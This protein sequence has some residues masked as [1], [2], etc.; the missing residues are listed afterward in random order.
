MS[1]S[2]GVLR[3]FLLTSALIA[4]A[5]VRA[6]TTSPDNASPINGAA[7]VGQ[8]EAATTPG[9]PVP[10][11]D[12]NAAAAAQAQAQPDVS[13]PGGAGDIVVTGQRNIVRSSTEVS[14]VL[15]SADIARTGEGDIAGALARVTGLSVVGNGYVYVRGLGDRYSLALL[16]GL[17]LPSPEPLKRVVPL[18]L[19]ATTVI[20]SSLVQKSYSANFPGEFGGGVINLTTISA[21]KESFLTISGGGG[22]DTETTAHLGYTYYGSSL[23]W[24]G[25]TNANRAPT[26]ALKD[27]FASGKR[28]GDPDVDKQAIATGIFTGRNSVVQRNTDI[29]ANSSASV[30]AGTSFDLGDSTLGIIANAGYSNSWRTRDTTQQTPSSADLSQKELDYQRVI[31]DDHIVVNGL[32]GVSLESGANKV[33]LT[34]LFIR[35]TLKQTRLGRGFET[36]TGFTRLDEDTAWYE[37]Q[38]IDTQLAGQFKLGNLGV[39]VRGG[40]ANTK[41]NAPYELSAG[42]VR[43]NRAND[44]FGNY[45][46][47]RLNN[48]QTGSASATFSKL[49]EDLYSGGIDLSYPLLS[50][51]TGTIGYAYSDTK[52]R[53]ERR[54]FQFI[55]PSDFPAGAG[56][57]RPDYLLG[58]AVIKA[59]NVSLVETTESD[60][61][62]LAKLR[63]HAGYAKINADFGGGLGLDAGVRYENGRQ[64]VSPLQIFDTPT[65]SLASTEIK[66]DYWLPAATL[67]WGFAP[68]MQLRVNASKT[69][70]RPQFRELV[71]QQFFDPESN[72]E[73]RGN[74]LLVDSQLYNAEARWEW[75]FAQDQRLSLGGFYKRIEHPIEAFTGFSDNQ[76]QT[77]YANAPRARLYG[78]EVEL[79]KYFDLGLH[80]DFWGNHRAVVIANYTY[81]HSKIGVKDSDIV[82]V[83]G[84]SD[85]PATNFFRDGVPLTG[86]SDHLANLQLG[87]EST[88]H[89]QQTTLLLSYASKRVTS[90]GPA[91]QPDIYEKP[92]FQL[93]FV[94]REGVDFLGVPTEIKF[95]V[96]NLTGTKYQEYQE[97]GD[98]RVYYN[99]YKVGT[100]VNLGASV[101]F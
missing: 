5:M 77:S 99:R 48:G 30:S 39:D 90:R 87:V 2:M 40:Y 18:D 36:T 47:N 84:T 50:G 68:D 43:S 75:Y 37:R 89:L 66:R 45:F 59:F 95:E 41:R 83:Y 6:Q 64:E 97:L 91:G 51:V 8:P 100:T 70:A 63:T 26:Q 28:I 49:N 86:Q 57:L 65:S 101:T 74:P 11:A 55:A 54:D 81:S 17:P 14:S 71:F 88:D 32:L 61:A 29:P 52:R 79:Q 98:N 10:Q 78:A 7:A 96:R 42:Y 38:L 22:I 46:I 76:P 67:T 92:G 23:D 58:P 1:K 94:M 16:N 93:D 60:P 25:F 53:S 80:G 44:P 69:I 33:R 20:A 72:R 34:N 13:I 4:P 31:T 9:N 27:F 19:F 82:S 56:L 12:D 15:S 73:F 3:A 62:F 85:Q 35:D 24:S 21:P